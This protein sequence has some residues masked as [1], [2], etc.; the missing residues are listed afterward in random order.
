MINLENVTLIAIDTDPLC[1]SLTK[2]AAKHTLSIIKPNDFIFFGTEKLNI[3]EKFYEI[4]R[5]QSINEYS[6]FV[7]KCLWP[8]IKTDYI[9]IIHWDGFPTNEECW[10]NTFLEYDYIGA[11][12]IWAINGYSVGNG[13]FSIRSRKLVSLCSENHIQQD[14]NFLGGAEDVMIG[15]KYRDYLVSKG[16][17]FPSNHIAH[18]FSHELGE[19]NIQSFGFHSVK[20]IPLFVTENYLI[21]NI[22]SFAKKLKGTALLDDFITSASLSGHNKFIMKFISLLK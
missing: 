21:E 5:F 3:G 18:Q 19:R 6:K 15:V 4:N 10:Q 1:L 2:S 11:P 17:S 8:F 12:W 14:L 7:L 16:C 13:G 22:E 9:M 20:N